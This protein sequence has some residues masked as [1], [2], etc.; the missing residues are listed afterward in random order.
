MPTRKPPNAKEM[1]DLTAALRERLGK[2]DPGAKRAHRPPSSTAELLDS[3]EKLAGSVQSS[4]SQ[5]IPCPSPDPTNQR[6]SQQGI[7]GQSTLVQDVHV[8]GSDILDPDSQLTQADQQLRDHLCVIMENSLTQW[9]AELRGF[10]HRTA[11]GMP[12]LKEC[13]KALG[14]SQAE[15]QQLSVALEFKQRKIVRRLRLLKKRE[16]RLTQ[17]RKTLAQSI[18][19]Q[20][21]ELF[22]QVE[23]ERIAQQERLLSDSQSESAAKLSADAKLYH[24]LTQ[25]RQEI[26]R[27]EEFASD[28]RD[29]LESAHAQIELLQDS[30]IAVSAGDEG[31]NA[32]Q[33][34]QRL[35]SRLNEVLSEMADL[36]QQNEELAARLAAQTTRN[37]KASTLGNIVSHEQ[38][39]WEQR[40]EMILQQLDEDEFADANTHANSDNDVQVDAHAEQRLEVRQII[41]TTEHEIARRDREIEELREI[42]RTQSEAR[43][44]VAIGAAGLAAMLDT[45]QLIQQERQKL[46]DIQQQW[47]A[48]LRQAEIDLSMERAKLARE[49]MELEKQQ[50]EQPAERISAGTEKQRRWLDYLGLKEESSERAMESSTDLPTDTSP[51]KR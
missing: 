10:M 42:V 24:E 26:Q 35:K 38:M 46:K 12:G 51:K 15:L 28:A 6:Q 7:S 16:A 44:G 40:K 34:T 29:L 22:L 45:D 11:D 21:A 13:V 1:A 14:R 5:S 33:D 36:R 17:Q 4:H 3:I 48:K 41:E 32:D 20:R 2:K 39:S 19:A 18:R 25:A 31:G 47:E 27:L 43:D 8:P 37:I 23:R 49:R 30:P 50:T 9:F